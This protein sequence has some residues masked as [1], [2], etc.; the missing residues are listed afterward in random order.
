MLVFVLHPVPAM[1]PD[2]SAA[3]KQQKDQLTWDLAGPQRRQ[4]LE[5]PAHSQRESLTP[6]VSAIK[7]MMCSHADT[8]KL[9]CIYAVKD[10]HHD[11]PA[12]ALLLHDLRHAIRQALCKARHCLHLDLCGFES[13]Q[14]AASEYTVR[15]QPQCRPYSL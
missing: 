13:A 9:A 7:H 2:M 1:M 8:Q 4:A 10:G 5:Q 12:N 6:S 3:V 15:S 14:P 11:I